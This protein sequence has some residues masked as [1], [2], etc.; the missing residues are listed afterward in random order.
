MRHFSSLIAGALAVLTLSPTSS[1]ANLAGQSSKTPLGI[2]HMVF[3][4]GVEETR[5]EELRAWTFGVGVSLGSGDGSGTGVLAHVIYGGPYW[6]VAASGGPSFRR[7]REERQAVLGLT[8]HYNVWLTSDHQTRIGW[9][10]GWSSGVA[11]SAGG[12]AFDYRLVVSRALGTSSAVFGAFGGETA[13]TSSDGARSTRPTFLGGVSTHLGDRAALSA[14]FESTL[15]SAPDFRFGG[16]LHLRPLFE[17]DVPG[18]GSERSIRSGT[19]WR[20]LLRLR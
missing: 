12:Q 11:G 8:Y 6:Y 19:P 18:P 7:S 5:I 14:G 20:P 10:A 3:L 13:K 16:V 1:I 9:Q 17:E 4:P 2:G 15:T